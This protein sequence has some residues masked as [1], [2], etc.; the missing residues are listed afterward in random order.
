MRQ[1]GKALFNIGETKQIKLKFMRYLLSLII[2]LFTTTGYGQIK[3]PTN[4]FLMKPDDNENW[5]T[6]VKGVEMSQ[7]LTVIQNRLLLKTNKTD[8]GKVAPMILVDGIIISDLFNQSNR[9]R[10]TT[11]LTENKIDVIEVIDT[12]PDNLYIEKQFTGIIIIK[13]SNRKAKKQLKKLK[14]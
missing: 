4:S 13:M 1:K 3:D 6:Y 7:K 2:I 5:L 10:F 12:L 8:S 14:L 9:E 11:F